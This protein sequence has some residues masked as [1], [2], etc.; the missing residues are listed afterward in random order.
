MVA[1]WFGGE[2]PMLVDT[3]FGEPEIVVA[4]GGPTRLWLA[5]ELALGRV[6]VALLEKLPAPTGLSKALG[7]QARAMEIL[8]YR[9]ILHRF[10]AGNPVPPFL[11][12][13]MFPWF[14]VRSI[15]RTRGRSHSPG[16]GGS[17]A[18]GTRD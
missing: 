10:T 5:C 11:N 8:D 1:N 4:G 16:A 7:L 6:R 18:C 15:F 14:R 9:G 3:R 17:A 12:F 13:A 2:L